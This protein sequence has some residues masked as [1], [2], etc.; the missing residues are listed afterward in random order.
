[1]SMSTRRLGRPSVGPCAAF[2]IALLAIASDAGPSPAQTHARTGRAP[3]GPAVTIVNNFAPPSQPLSTASIE[4]RLPDRAELLFQGVRTA[5]TGARRSFTTPSL[6]RGQ[7][8]AYE[9][10][11]R[12]S[13]GK[14]EVVR[15]ERITVRAGDRVVVDLTPSPH[16][17]GMRLQDIPRE[18]RPGADAPR[19]SVGRL[20]GHMAV[21]EFRP[22]AVVPADLAR[23][24]TPATAVTVTPSGR[25]SVTDFPPSAA[26]ARRPGRMSVTDL[27]K[28]LAPIS[29]PVPAPLR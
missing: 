6:A 14:G 8:Y 17:G 23:A 20:P 1:M 3:N 19:T 11:A 9:V 12:W 21:R 29:R 10:A 2:L 4:V 27:E 13:E 18:G 24:T 5:Q 16:Q 25:M 28:T 15:R 7:V 26:P 22:G